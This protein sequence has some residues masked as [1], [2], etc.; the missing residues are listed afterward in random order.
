MA[1][2]LVSV[3]LITFRQS[4]RRKAKEHSRADGWKN[5]GGGGGSRPRLPGIGALRDLRSSAVEVDQDLPVLQ[6][7]SIRFRNHIHVSV[8]PN[9][10]YSAIAFD[11]Q[12]NSIHV[13][14][15]RNSCCRP[16]E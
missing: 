14:A 4:H 7:N 16:S 9:S 5:D 10:F 3:E 11:L 6:H 8:Q 1:S 12:R 13:A 2:I 15:H